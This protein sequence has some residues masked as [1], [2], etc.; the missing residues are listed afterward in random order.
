[1]LVMYTNIYIA[2]HELWGNGDCRALCQGDYVALCY[3]DY[4]ALCLQNLTTLC[5]GEINKLVIGLG[6][7]IVW[8]VSCIMHCII[9]NEM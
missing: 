1:M 3:G 9:L 2:Y 8:C 4:M 7:S 5:Q 6:E